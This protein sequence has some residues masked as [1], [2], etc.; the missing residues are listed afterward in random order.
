MRHAEN[1]ATETVG[2]PGAPGARVE[3]SDFGPIAS[4]SVDLRP[5]TVFVGPSNSGKTYLAT[6]LY[7]LSRSF[8][9]FPRYPGPSSVSLRSPLFSE[10]ESAS[11]EEWVS[12]AKALATRGREIR[13][14]DFPS[15]FRTRTQSRLERV[16]TSEEG[17]RLEIKRCFDIDSLSDL[18][19]WTAAGSDARISASI[20]DANQELW[21]FTMKIEDKGELVSESYTPGQVMHQAP[22]LVS[23]VSANYRLGNPDLMLPKDDDFYSHQFVNLLNTAP[24]SKN[25]EIVKEIF[26]RAREILRFN[27]IQGR[28]YY[29]PA[30]RSGIMQS[31]RVIASSLVARATRGGLEHFPALPTLSGMIADF[32]EHLIL[33]DN[34]SEHYMS[35]RPF[36]RNAQTWNRQSTSQGNNPVKEMANE[37]E[38]KLLGGTIKNLGESKSQYPDFIYVP[39]ESDKQLRM[40]RSSSMVSELAPL[41]LFLRQSVFPQDMLIIEEPEAHLHPAAQTRIAIVLA[42]LARAGV[43]V[44]VT[45]HSDWLLKQ[46]GNLIRQGELESGA[47]R[48]TDPSLLPCSLQAEHVGVWLFQTN[49]R[50]QGSKVKE[51]PYDRIDGI[52]PTEY[53]DVDE[54]L[55]N[56]SADL[57]NLLDHRENGGNF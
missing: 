19:R 28:T 1:T 35:L 33:Y 40:S 37:L 4:A 13:L 46:I 57:Q 12:L 47:I 54:E 5:L 42:K 38:Q 43:R 45:T 17:L 27:G 9:G 25:R 6:V 2:S 44:I 30:A 23:P 20:T 10:S 29:L 26:S 3:V 18:V 53:A 22:Q 55:Y 16:V 51:I 49:D 50:G 36:D 11:E 56:Q 7:A 52:E 48:G 8:G 24:S 21:S 31:H 32:M 41:I 14:N 15:V 34:P 39:D